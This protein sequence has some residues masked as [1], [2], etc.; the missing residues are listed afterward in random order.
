MASANHEPPSHV[1]G[2]LRF[3]ELEERFGTDSAYSILTTLEQFEGIRREWIANLSAEERL[4]NVFSLMSDNM[5]Y[6]TRH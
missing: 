1:F 6:Q 3:A 5:V 4:E 2:L